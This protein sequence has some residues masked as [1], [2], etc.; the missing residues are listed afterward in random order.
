M[1]HPEGEAEDKQE[2]QQSENRV[3]LEDLKDVTK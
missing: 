2:N 3:N 1:N